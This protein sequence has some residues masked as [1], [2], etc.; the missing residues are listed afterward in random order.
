PR[1]YFRPDAPGQYVFQLIVNNGV[2]D[3]PAAR[4]TI[5]A[6]NSPVPPTAN[7]GKPVNVR[8]GSAATVDGSLSHPGQVGS[9]LT[10]RWTG[11]QPPAGSLVTGASIS[12]ATQALASFVP[13]LVGAY[14]LTLTVSDAY[15]SSSDSVTVTASDPNVAPNAVAG[16]DRR[17]LPGLSVPLDGTSS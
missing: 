17:I 10:Y 13:D 14:V 15:G 6:Y 1:P 4:V 16:R 11:T 7:A 9:A 5:T 8:R 2:T 12:S 3:S